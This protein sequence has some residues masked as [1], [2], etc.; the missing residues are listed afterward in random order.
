MR[1]RKEETSTD[2]QTAHFGKQ[3]LEVNKHS[4]K[5]ST[6]KQKSSKRA[7]SEGSKQEGKGRKQGKSH[8]IR[9]T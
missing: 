7:K 5:N 2:K 6:K 1:E 9:L 4:K 8:F 3:A